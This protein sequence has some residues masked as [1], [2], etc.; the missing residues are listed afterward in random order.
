MRSTSTAALLS[1]FIFPGA[2]QL[3]L[4]RRMRACVFLVPTLV[5]GYVFLDDLM[6]RASALADQLLSGTLAPDPAALAARLETQGSTSTLSTV[7]AA[8][9]V[10]CWI[11]SIIDAVILAR[12]QKSGSKMSSAQ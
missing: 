5:A 3:Y 10:I 12:G 9:L 6:R 7:C 4:K 8:V 2:G 11:A 1:A